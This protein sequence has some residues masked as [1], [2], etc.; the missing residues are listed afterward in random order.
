MWNP[1]SYSR[2][3]AALGCAGREVGVGLMRVRMTFLWMS[4]SHLMSVRKSLKQTLTHLFITGNKKQLQV[5][6]SKTTA[7]RIP[8]WSPTVVLTRRHS[9]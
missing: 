9:G 6:K 2:V 3:W 1:I 7:P 5:T 4:E 8:A